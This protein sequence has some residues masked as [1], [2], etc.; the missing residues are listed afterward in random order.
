LISTGTM[1]PPPFIEPGQTWQA[2]LKGLDLPSL[3]VKFV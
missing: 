3:T 1:L 2:Q